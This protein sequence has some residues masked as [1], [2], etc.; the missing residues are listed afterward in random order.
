MMRSKTFIYCL[1]IVVSVATVQ[2]GPVMLQYFESRWETI[3]KKLPDVY[4]SG[5][6][7]FWLPPPGKAD[8]GGYSVGYDVYDRFDLGKPF[9]QTLYGTEAAVKQMVRAAHRAGL[10]CYFDYVVNHNG[11]RDMSTPGFDAAGGYPGFV[12]TLPTDIDGDFHGAFETGD[13]NM[14]LAGLIDIA[15]EKNHVFIRHPVVP[16][17]LNIPRQSPKAENRRFYPDRDL[18][19]NSLGI[20]PF[21]LSNPMAGDPTAENATGLLLRYTQWM[22]EVIGADG[23]RIDA[24]KHIPAW[25]FSAFFDNVCYQRGRPDLAGNPRTPYSFGECYTGDFGVLGQYIRKDGFGNRDVLDF[26]LFFKIQ[27][28]FNGGGFG[29]MRQLEFASVDGIDGN[30][31]DGSVG[32]TFVSS[33]DNGPPALDNVAYAYILTRT[34]YPLVYFNAHEFGTGR[35]FPY[36]GRGDALGGDYGDLIPRLVDISRRY[37]KGAYYTRWIDQDVFVYERDNSLLVGLNDRGDAGYD[38]RTVYTNFR[39]VTLVELTGNAADPVV[40]ANGDIYPTITIGNDGMA[41]IRVPRN[42][43]NATTHNRGFVMYG[44]AVPTQ[45][46]TLAGVTQVLAPETTAV[47]NGVRRHTPIHVVKGTTFSVTVQTAAT[48]AEDNALI[49]LD[50]GVA[51]DANPG[52]FITSGEF[53]GFEEFTELKSPR[54]SGGSGTYRLTINTSGLEEGMH[55]LE[56]VAFL[57]RPPGTPAAYSSKRSV[58]YLDRV[59]P[60]VS[61]LYPSTTGTSDVQSQSYTVVAQCPDFTADSMHIFF[62]LP[63][64][65]NFVGNVNSSNQMTRVDRHEFRYTWN[66][67]PPRTISITILTCERTGNYSGTRFEPVNAVLPQPD[68]AFG[69]DLDFNQGSVNFQPV[70]ATITTAAYPYDFVVRVSNV[71]R[72]FPADY[73]VSLEVDGITYEAQPYNPSLL[74]PVNRLV[75]N[76][77]NLSDTW[78]EFRFRWSG[79]TR[80]THHFVARA[81][82]T[83]GTAPENSVSAMVTVPESVAGPN[84]SIVSPTPGT[85]LN[86]PTSLP[87]TVATN[88]LA[89]S[90]AAYITVDGVAQLIEMKNDFGGSTVTLSATV[91]NYY[92]SDASAKI[93]LRNGTW[94]IRAIVSTGTDGSGIASEAMT[95]VTVTGMGEAPV[96]SVPSIDGNISEFFDRAP[97][98]VSAA[99][100]A[101]NSPAVADFGADGSLT[102]LHGRVRDGVLYLAVRGDMFNGTNPN[103]N[104]TILYID[105]DAGAGTGARKMT[106]PTDLTD[107]STPKRQLVSNSGFQLNSALVSQ[108]IGFDAAIIINGTNP[109]DYEMVG[110]GT[111]GVAGS[112]SNFSSLSGSFAFGRG[113]Q[114][115]PG[116]PGTTIAGPS[117]F[118]VAIPLSALGNPNPRNLRFVVVTTSDTSFPSPNTLP[119]NAQNTFDSVQNLD[120]VAAFPV[121]PAVKINEV[122]NGSPDW[123]ELY[124]PSSNPVNLSQWSLRWSDAN[125][126]T[127]YLGLSGLSL[128]GNGFAV[129]ADGALT[130]SVG[131]FVVSSNLPYYPPRAASAALVDPYGIAVDYV[132]WYGLDLSTFGDTAP[133]GTSFT[134]WAVGFDSQVANRS[135]S[136]DANSTDTD[137]DTDWTLNGPT[138]AGPNVP[139]SVVTSWLEYE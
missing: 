10:D 131:E 116:A 113:L 47:P 56:T 20:Y 132:R 110:F 86:A 136:R 40:N 83:S 96:S 80:G 37:A 22:L 8:T 72:S 31:N 127:A 55:F 45:T 33:H 5:Y 107:S 49:K 100:G 99:D 108:G 121:Y 76:D 21:N 73:T 128:A 46:Q 91:G 3:E 139:V 54:A 77:Q 44:L 75:Q 29:D 137:Q 2:A 105:V 53:A 19:P 109:L 17:P 118:E 122:F 25:Y 12:L 60:P 66:N 34:G 59:P 101:G 67:I 62:D 126:L 26:P 43:T 36:G 124:N 98:A 79:Y 123:V 41:T 30:A 32:V 63:P 134:G 11:F 70:P 103:M 104:A 97:L 90:A 35:S 87:V 130:P 95:S 52:L 1:G 23:F 106:P 125:G 69:V 111:G 39:N 133:A 88:S 61:L 42:R 81:R 129:V 82:L 84:I 117:G 9:D 58:I 102:E 24:E 27:A 15:Q 71:G 138:P 13:L 119:E 78:D 112:T 50:G 38:T 65:Y 135:L 48:P 7:S 68:M 115:S 85:T 28:V 120:G 94:T 14:R 114:I 92:Q 6:T 16:D 74:P 89:R 64:G 57:P 4:V 51:I 93:Q 18:P